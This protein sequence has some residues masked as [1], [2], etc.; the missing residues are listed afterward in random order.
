MFGSVPQDL[1][2]FFENQGGDND[3]WFEKQKRTC[4][5]CGV[6]YHSKQVHSCNHRTGNLVD[7]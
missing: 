7:I 5:K 3:D 4:P 1:Q 2:N 6:R